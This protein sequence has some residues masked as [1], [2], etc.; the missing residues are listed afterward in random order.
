MRSTRRK[1]LAGLCAA[2]RAQTLEDPTAL[3]REPEGYLQPGAVLRIPPGRYPALTFTARGTPQQPIR[4]EA[5]DPARPPVIEGLVYLPRCAWLTIDGLVFENAEQ[6]SINADDGGE[7]GGAVGLKFH[8]LTFRDCGGDPL[9]LAGVDRFEVTGCRFKYWRGSAIAMVG[10]HDGVVE[11]CSFYN[12]H[13]FAGHGVQIKGGSKDVRVKGCF[14]CGLAH[15]WINIGGSSLRSVF[16]PADAPYEAEETLVEGNRFVD[17]N[18]AVVWSAADGGIVRRNTIYRP[19]EWVCRIMQEGN[20]ETL[21]CRRGVFERNLVVYE[22]RQL[23]ELVQ[24][25]SGA[26]LASFV[27]RENAWFDERGDRYPR[28]RPWARWLTPSLDDLPVEETGGVYGV[29]P[30]LTDRGRP[31]MRICNS[32]LA[33]RFPGGRVGA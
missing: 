1:W 11:N 28:Y 19:R 7:L 23:R 16:R 32:S 2:A 30:E 21:P 25:R 18:A 27:F 12:W 5:L 26:D 29:D 17:G 24:K 31:T 14:F 20:D 8:N 4:I 9:K 22:G 15:R 6:H 33:E 3:T 10:C 13:S